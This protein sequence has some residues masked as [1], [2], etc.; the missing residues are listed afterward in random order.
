MILFITCGVRRL[1]N[2]M[3]PAWTMK[4]AR[5]RIATY[6]SDILSLVLSFSNPVCFHTNLLGSSYFRSSEAFWNNR[7]LVLQV[8]LDIVPDLDNR[9][10]NHERGFWTALV[11]RRDFGIYHRFFGEIRNLTTLCLLNNNGFRGL[12]FG[13][14]I[15]V[16]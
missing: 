5:K 10:D 14:I 11:L 4:R 9:R 1:G 6:L 12:F 13:S 8:D 7:L 3:I 2:E 15:L 16:S